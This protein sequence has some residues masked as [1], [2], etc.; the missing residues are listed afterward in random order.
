MHAGEYKTT[1]FTPVI[2]AMKL[3]EHV[4]LITTNPNKFPEY[5]EI[6][7]PEVKKEGKD[8]RDSEER[9]LILT[10]DSL[11]RKV[12]EQAYKIFILA[13]MANEINV[14]REPERTEERLRKQIRAAELCEEQLATIQLCRKRFHLSYRKIK[15]WGDKVLE[16]RDSIKAWHNSDKSRFKNL[17]L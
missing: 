3:Y 4:D 11:T 17:N 15:F 5:V 16:V 10:Q 8:G 6:C 9:I 7:K 14:N 2:L 12:R 1:D 13:H